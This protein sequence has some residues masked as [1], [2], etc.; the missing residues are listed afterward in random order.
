MSKR[1]GIGH[2]ITIQHDILPTRRLLQISFKRDVGYDATEI[3][4]VTKNYTNK[5]KHTISDRK[6]LSIFQALNIPYSN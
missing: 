6:Q 4:I 2:L 1:V 3:R 5:C